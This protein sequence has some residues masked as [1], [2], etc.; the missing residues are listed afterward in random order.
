MGR[1]IG[2]IRVS[3]VDQNTDRQLPDVQLDVTYEEKVSG[4][5]RNRPELANMIKAVTAGDTVHV[6][7]MDRLARNMVDLVTLVKEITDKGAAIQFHK[8]QLKFSGDK[9]DHTAELMLGILGSV[10]QFERAI[11][12]ERQAEGIAAAKARGVYD[13]HGAKREMTPEKVAELQQRVAAGEKK[14]AI[15]RDMRISRDTLYRYL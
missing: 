6:H 7:S 4:K 11:I 10:A 3:S 9:K 12:R 14:A 1:T 8:E 2:Y 15:A 5:D 13:K